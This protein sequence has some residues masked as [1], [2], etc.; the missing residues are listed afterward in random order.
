MGDSSRNRVLATVLF[1]DI[2]GS[3]AKLHKLG[4]DAWRDLLDSHDRLSKELVALNRGR[5]IRS[6]GDGI[7]AT[8]DGPGR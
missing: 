6:T 3:T 4:D 8:F 1:S 7:L 2:V 5:L